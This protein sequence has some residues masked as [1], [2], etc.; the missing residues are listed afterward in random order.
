M[1]KLNNKISPSLDAQLSEAN[2]DD[3]KWED[4]C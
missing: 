2:M 1:Y 4:D 3:M